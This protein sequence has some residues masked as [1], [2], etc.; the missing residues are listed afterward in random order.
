MGSIHDAFPDQGR[1]NPVEIPQRVKLDSRIVVLKFNAGADPT[2]PG[3]KCMPDPKLLV[4][5]PLRY[6]LALKSRQGHGHPSTSSQRQ[7]KF[8]ADEDVHKDRRSYC[9]IWNPQLTENGAWDTKGI[10]T[11]H[12]DGTLVT[13][14]AT[15]VGAVGILSEV[16]EHPWAPDDFSWLL[17]LKFFGYCLSALLLIIYCLTILFSDYLWEMFH[18][19]GMNIAFAMFIG[20]A[21][22]ISTELDSSRSDRH[23]CATIGGSINF[24]YLATAGL[25]F[26]ESHAIF[27]SITAG[28]I[29]GRTYTY[30]CLGWAAGF[31]GVGA[32]VFVNLSEFGDDPR[33][34]VGW[35]ADAKMAFF[36]PV[37]GLAGTSVI[38]M[39]V[40]MCNLSTPQLR[41]KSFIEDQGSLARGFTAFTVLYALTWSWT[42]LSYIKYEGTETPDLYPAFQVMNSWMGVFLFILFGIGSKRF[43]VAISGSIN[44]RVRN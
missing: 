42:P 24:F 29:G 16:V 13:C 33:C 22:M 8:H 25:V 19:L 26:A 21:L 23:T 7:L 15:E 12:T 30:L 4:R 43:R 44:A 28:V 35:K 10:K 5:R 38:I 9:A 32:N 40:A 39:F 11:V 34:M 17:I 18:I 1:R 37:I 3:K 27:R 36:L 31:F 14:Y 20:N 2:N 41:K 6:T